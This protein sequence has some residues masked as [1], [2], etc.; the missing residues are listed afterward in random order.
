[1]RR[2]RQIVGFSSELQMDPLVDRKRPED[3]QVRVDDGWRSEC[4]AA[5]RTK[6]YRGHRR[7]GI[8]IVVRV[9]RSDASQQGNRWKN[10]VG[11]LGII[12]SIERRTRRGHRE[13][14]SRISREGPI[15][16]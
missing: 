12:W 16:L 15:Q 7:I 1:M 6:A 2:V 9:P 4:V 3:A 11:G 5:G 14:K 8:G 10:L 13:R